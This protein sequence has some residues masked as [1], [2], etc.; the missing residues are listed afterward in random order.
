M[1]LLLLLLL[2]ALLGLGWRANVAGSVSTWWQQQSGGGRKTPDLVQDFTT[3]LQAARQYLRLNDDFQTDTGLQE[4]LATRTG[5]DT[6]D[7]HALIQDAQSAFPEYQQMAALQT[8]RATEDEL[9]A[10]LEAWPEM[11][12]PAYTH[13]AVKVHPSWGNLGWHGCVVV[14]QKLP[15][16]TPEALGKSE[17]SLFYTVCALCARKQAC[18]IP[19]QTRSLCLECGGCKRTYAMIASGSDGQYRYVNEFLEGYEPPAMY[20]EGQPRL[21][22]LMIIWRTVSA[23]CQYVRDTGTDDHDAWQTARETQALGR[24]DCEDSAIL[25]ADWLLARGFEARVALGRYAERGGH[26]WVVVR[27]EGEEYLLEATEGST[28]ARK[29]PLLSEVGARYVP[30]FLFDREAFY[31]RVQP[32]ARWNGDFWSDKTWMRVAP[33]AEGR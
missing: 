21:S 22:E 1:R 2:I 25:L 26:A 3:R 5:Q 27:L 6:Q 17:T 31:T 4:W 14:G 15:A 8:W 11:S 28:G 29:A 33:R 10:A 9:A 30:E 7:M 12:E 20:P 13:L 19:R 32:L 16:F 23:G 24:G 18:E